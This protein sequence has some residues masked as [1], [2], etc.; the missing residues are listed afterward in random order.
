MKSL[1]LDAMRVAA[2]DPG[3]GLPPGFHELALEVH[4]NDPDWTPEQ[5]DLLER[6]FNPDNPYFGDGRAR[7]FCIPG[8]VRAAAFYREGQCADAPRGAF[9]GYWES[10]GNADAEALV[11]AAVEAWAREQGAQSLTGPV[12]FSIHGGCRLRFDDARPW[13][14]F[15]GEPS[16]PARDVQ[17]LLRL[18]FREGRR[19]KSQI[20]DFPRFALQAFADYGRRMQSRGY[21]IEPF[22]PAHWEA[23]LE[24]LYALN[25]RVWTR[26]YRYS[27][28]TL[29]EFEH[30]YAGPLSRR[31]C[32][33]TSS[34]VYGPAGDIAAFAIFIPNYA[35]LTR[36][37]AGADRVLPAALNYT[38]HYPRLRAPREIIVKTLAVSPEHR[39]KRLTWWVS[40]GGA[41]R[42]FERYERHLVA[43]QQNAA[44]FSRLVEPFSN[45][46]RTYAMFEKALNPA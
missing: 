33:H 1:R 36:Q 9:F 2:A 24:E 32:P 43:M 44:V 29:E 45:G 28:L 35:T 19:C 46:E 26:N 16:N 4:A 34:L 17:A 3:E 41:V 42:G 20:V 7:L 5:R 15:V 11:M 12:N 27:P 6:A 38:E 31:M 23:H 14:T 21:D 37:A 39:G 40:C 18:G 25:C 8:Q 13:P 10:S 22:T 30:G